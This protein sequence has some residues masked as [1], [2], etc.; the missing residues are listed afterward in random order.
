MVLGPK[1]EM[2]RKVLPVV[3]QLAE[4]KLGPES[5]VADLSDDDMMELYQTIR[6]NMQASGGLYIGCSM[7][8]H[9]CQPNAVA[10]TKGRNDAN[11]TVVA[12]VD[13]KEGQEVSI[14]Y[15]DFS[16]PVIDR[17]SALQ[18]MYGFRCT[19]PKCCT[20]IDNIGILGGKQWAEGS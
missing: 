17:Q 12:L 2:L 6:T 18:A 8:N 3:R 14:P 7:I 10:A 11:Y 16:Q 13:I 20:E 19:C 5:G 9:S 4:G 1:E 15:I